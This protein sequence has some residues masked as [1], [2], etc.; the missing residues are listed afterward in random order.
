MVKTDNRWEG[1]I[2]LNNYSCANYKTRNA[3]NISYSCPTLD[4]PDEQ[5]GFPIGHVPTILLCYPSPIDGH[6]V[7]GYERCFIGA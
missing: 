7:A 3:K 6:C 1:A 4:L 2:A 5:T